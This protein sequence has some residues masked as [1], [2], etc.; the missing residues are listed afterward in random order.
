MALRQRKRKPGGPASGAG[1]ALAW[2]HSA[3]Q[4][5]LQMPPRKIGHAPSAGMQYTK[6]YDMLFK[7]I[8]KSIVEN[9]VM[10]A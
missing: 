10:M 3:S 4:D 5:P 1:P 9:P 8:R 7:A 2:R 6:I